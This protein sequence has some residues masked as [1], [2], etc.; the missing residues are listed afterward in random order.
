MEHLL[1]RS[2]IFN[3][4]RSTT[5]LKIIFEGLV[6]DYRNSFTL[7]L[8]QATKPPNYVLDASKWGKGSTVVF[9]APDTMPQFHRS[10]RG[11][12]NIAYKP[13][14]IS[15]EANL[16]SAACVHLDTVSYLHTL[17]LSMCSGYANYNHVLQRFSSWNLSQA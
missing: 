9:S 12:V 13:R 4:P 1:L 8:H 10:S 3:A 16:N 5:F 6:Q 11:R 7:V 15:L 17:S 14:V 2:K